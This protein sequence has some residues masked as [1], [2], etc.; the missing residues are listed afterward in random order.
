MILC[1]CFL[2][3]QDLMYW[4]CITH[5]NFLMLNS[6]KKGL[7]RNQNKK[8]KEKKQTELTKKHKK[9]ILKESKSQQI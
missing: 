7:G 4:C 2:E 9:T 6:R 1:E 3:F 5:F 8:E